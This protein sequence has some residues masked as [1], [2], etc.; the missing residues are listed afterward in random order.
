MSYSNEFVALR[1]FG[2]VARKVNQLLGN[3]PGSELILDEGPE[4]AGANAL[5]TIYGVP[6]ANGE[7][8]G[9]CAE[10]VHVVRING[11]P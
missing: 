6:L 4:R 1:S 10:R 5:C 9:S 7:T 8:K 3:L 11:L 2:H